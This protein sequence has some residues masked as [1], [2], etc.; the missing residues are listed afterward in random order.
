[1][2]TVLLG[3]P[4]R[5]LS[6]A[7]AIVL[8][9]AFVTTTLLVTTSLDA[10]IRQSVAGSIRDARVVVSQEGNGAPLRR[11][12]EPLTDATVT[13]LAALPG[14]SAVRAVARAY[15]TLQLPGRQ[16]PVIG[17]GAPDLTELT[18]LTKGRLPHVPGEVAINT[19]LATVHDTG[20]GDTLS[21]LTAEGTEHV[22]IVGVVEAGADTTDS[23][24][25]PLL[26][27]SATDL[28]RWT[29]QPGYEYLYVSG[30][31][32]PEALAAQVASSGV[33]D[34]SSHVRTAEE[35]TTERLRQ[36]TRG[37]EQLALMLLAFGGVALATAAMVITNTFTILTA[38]RTRRLALL[39]TVGATR[40]QI[41]GHVL[42]E[43]ALLALVASAAGVGFGIGLGALGVRLAS[44]AT[45]F[46]LSTFAL[47]S[48]DL[49]VPFAAGVLVTVVAA[50]APARRAT[51][52][53]PLAALR[54]EA[55]AMSGP[56]SRPVRVGA[57]MAGAGVVLLSGGV[58]L[59][60]LDW[61]TAPAL[62][63]GMAGGLASLVG[64]VLVAPAFVPWLARR[65]GRPLARL[66]GAPAELAGEN[67][68]R[69]PTRAAATASALLLGVA[70]VTMMT[71]GAATGQAS[72]EA[73]L[74][75]QFPVD[76]RMFGQEAPLTDAQ[77]GLVLGQPTVAAAT[78]W[79]SAEARL[80]GS[81]IAPGT[82][83]GL[84]P[85]AATVLRSPDLMAGLDDATVL[86]GPDARVD[87][88]TPLTVTGP[89]GTRTL[90]ARVRPDL[91]APIVSAATARALDA[92]A[93]RSLG[94]RL[95]ADA[96]PVAA[97]DALA[98][99]A[100]AVAPVLA[101]SGASARVEV[102]RMIDGIL[103]VVLA[104]LAVAVLIALVGIGNTLGLSVLE[105]RRE[106]GLLRAL[107]LT[108]GQLRASLGWEALLLA[109]VATSVGVLLGSGYG[110][111]GVVVLL[112]AD[113][114]VVWVWP[115][116]RIALIAA[117][118]LLAGWL[119]SLLPATRAAR[120]PPA[121]AL[122]RDD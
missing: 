80:T 94:I 50:L 5:L 43:A 53:A 85:D 100:S 106:S 79:W 47:S 45:V 15:L 66:G 92:H 113:A 2:R 104:L 38:Q 10:S 86:V 114:P 27:A 90:T 111:A 44:G 31:G 40:A 19:A 88:G 97:P 3:A 42:A 93:Q 83:T 14:V 63:L 21:L 4:R 99:A 23:P 52:V 67:A 107:G 8:G 121:A 81:A 72:I 48:R 6:T 70:L 22:R 82:V 102:A 76:V 57:L 59:A 18:R 78:S 69:N 95:T 54:P 30:D 39:R 65:L 122:A 58:A 75:R 103:V 12:R 29:G 36:F 60:L 91:S 7:L 112:G 1:M 32:D 108:R 64:T 25:E 77:I 118:A 115:A 26:L 37:T 62:A 55:P 46:D 49:L 41:F 11:D 17:M 119:A 89:D 33:L 16:S 24:R 71:T 34:A 73:Q 109:G 28:G 51:R 87:D 101:E 74:D 56:A 120:V 9:V 84:A 117:I 13:E 116:A 110:L 35:E 105:R 61:G 68:V 20:V 96:D 98:E